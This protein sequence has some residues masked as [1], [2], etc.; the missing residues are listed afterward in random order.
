MEYILFTFAVVRKIS[1]FFMYSS[2]DHKLDLSGLAQT[3]TCN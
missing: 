3:E 1:K 2:Y